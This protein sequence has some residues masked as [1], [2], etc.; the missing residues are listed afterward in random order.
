MKY[1]EVKNIEKATHWVVE[2]GNKY[3]IQGAFTIGKL[4]K[5]KIRSKGIINTWNDNII[6]NEYWIKDDNEQW[7]QPFS[8]HNGKFVKVLI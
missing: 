8:L 5:L 7:C 1:I 6:E 4:Y 2:E 3:Y